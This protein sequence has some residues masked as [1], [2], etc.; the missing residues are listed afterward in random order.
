[1]LAML[2]IDTTLWLIGQHKQLIK[3]FKDKDVYANIMRQML[4]KRTFI[5][6]ILTLG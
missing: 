6:V 1:M 5:E 4:E 3:R 2:G